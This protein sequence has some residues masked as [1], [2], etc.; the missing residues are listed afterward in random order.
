MNFKTD[1]FR[2][3]IDSLNNEGYLIM[4]GSGKYQLS[5]SM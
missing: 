3:L 2:D 5:T 1:N 4:K